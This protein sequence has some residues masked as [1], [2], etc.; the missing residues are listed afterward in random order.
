MDT[1]NKNQENVTAAFKTALKNARQDGGKL[2]QEKTA[3]IAMAAI[4][5]L[6]KDDGTPLRFNPVQREMLR[7]MFFPQVKVR[8]SII[9]ATLASVGCTLDLTTEELLTKLLNPAALEKELAAVRT[10]APTINLREL[11]DEEEVS[12]ANDADDSEPEQDNTEEEEPVPTMPV[13]TPVKNQ[14]PAATK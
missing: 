7:A 11:V 3:T 4:D 10:K 1:T 13:K 12:A 6:F 14:K 2:T 9:R 5:Q 8:K